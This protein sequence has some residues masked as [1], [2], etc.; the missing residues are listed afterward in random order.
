MRR[1]PGASPRY[2]CDHDAP[3]R[4]GID[5]SALGVLQLS[6]LQR[7]GLPLSAAGWAAWAARYGV[8]LGSMPAVWRG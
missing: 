8:P 5:L 6:A 3:R 2:G 1:L 4:E 7:H